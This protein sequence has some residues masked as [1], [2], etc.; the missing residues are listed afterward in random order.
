MKDKRTFP[1]TIAGDGKD[2]I[3]II[4]NLAD[5]E[6]AMDRIYENAGRITDTLMRGLIE[7]EPSTKPVGVNTDDVT[8]TGQ[9]EGKKP[10]EV[11]EEHGDKGYREL[12]EMAEDPQIGPTTYLAIER[13]L[14]EY[15]KKRFEKT[16]PEEFAG[17]L[18]D[19]QC[20]VFMQLFGHAVTPKLKQAITDELQ[21][22]KYEDLIENAN[23]NEKK[24]MIRLI[25]QAYK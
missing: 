1:I 17:K 24:T 5:E 9:F 4:H 16:D 22:E 7:A 20:N 10:A 13:A 2:V 3:I 18:T 25:I 6:G 12:G 15:L 8:L 14:S 23:L 11:L 19:K 21:Y